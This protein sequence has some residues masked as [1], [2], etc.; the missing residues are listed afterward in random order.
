MDSIS[1][2]LH[3]PFCQHRCGYC[4][5][6]TYSGIE[7]LIPSYVEAMVREINFFSEFAQ[8]VV[9]L[10]IR[11]IYF[12]GGTPSYLPTE[13]I[14]KILLSLNKL[15][16]IDKTCEIT[17]EVNPGTVTKKKLETLSDLGIN[18][19]SIGVQ[20]SNPLELQMLERLHGYSQACTTVEDARAAGFKNISLDLIYGLPEQDI[21]TWEQSL[22]DVIG[23]HPE[24]ISLYALTVEEGTPLAVKVNSGSI[25][26]PDPDKAA[27]CYDFARE[28]LRKEGFIHYEISNWAKCDP[29][30]LPLISRHNSQYW[31]NQP[32]VGFGA[33]AHGF[34]GG[35]RIENVAN[36][37]RYVKQVNQASTTEFPFTPATENFSK[38]DRMLEM[39]EVMMMG[40]R[41]LAEGVSRKRFSERF[42]VDMR[43][44][45]SDEIQRLLGKGLVRWSGDN[46]DQLILS[47]QAYMIANQVFLEFI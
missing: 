33:G 31:M 15:F 9:E 12:G 8:S 26:E 35:Y 42:G 30:G 28:E 38:I 24:H 44:I 36:P 6:N 11:S 14:E 1:V 17:L 37:F 16:R 10:P 4:D 21:K 34:I 41:L 13:E 43:D 45:F 3:I 7:R 40:L 23:L 29:D 32:Y 27:D 22:H 39:Q 20:S 47:E 19:L 18:R 2:Y 46:G 5:F 25:P